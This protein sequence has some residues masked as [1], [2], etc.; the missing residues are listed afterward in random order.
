LKAYLEDLMP[1]TFSKASISDAAARAALDAAVDTARGLGVMQSVAVLD[2]SGR[3]KAF[4]RMD[5]A[6]V[7][8][9]EASQRKAYAALLGVPSAKVA[10]AAAGD[11]GF[12]STLATMRLGLVGGGLPILAEGQIVG[13]LGVGGATVEQD[14]AVAEAGVGVAEKAS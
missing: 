3:L 12:A 6:P 9:V 1:V 10:L 11:A 7:V 14:I 4:V 13:A 2:E 8:S 5:G